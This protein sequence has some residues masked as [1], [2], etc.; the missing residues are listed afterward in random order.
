MA[1]TSQGAGWWLASD[2]KWY[3]PESLPASTNSQQVRP[4]RERLF[5]KVARQADAHSDQLKKG[6]HAALGALEG[7]GVA[8]INKQTGE[9]KIKKIGAVKAVLRPTKTF[10]KAVNGVTAE[11]LREPAADDSPS[12]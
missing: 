6:A 11:H 4:Q 2:G 3:P 8:K 10:R 5:A 7:S 1:D 9:I 12:A